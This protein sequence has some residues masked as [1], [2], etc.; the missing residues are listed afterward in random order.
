VSQPVAEKVAPAVR[1][2]SMVEPVRLTL[3]LMHGVAPHVCGQVA[4]LN[5]KRGSRGSLPR[6][7]LGRGG[8]R[9]ALPAD[10]RFEARGVDRPHPVRVSPRLRLVI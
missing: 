9:I 3:I 10:A 2:P 7:S 1:R 6:V 4:S 5:V 8:R